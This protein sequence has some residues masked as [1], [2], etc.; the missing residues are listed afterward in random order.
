MQISSNIPPSSGPAAGLTLKHLVH[1]Q[2]GLKFAGTPVPSSMAPRETMESSDQAGQRVKD[3]N[4]FFK[5]LTT[6]NGV[7]ENHGHAE[8]SQYKYIDH[9]TKQGLEHENG[10]MQK[11][12][13]TPNPYEHVIGKT[14]ITAGSRNLAMASRVEYV[15]YDDGTVQKT[16]HDYKPGAF[17][18]DMPAQTGNE[19]VDNKA[20][21]NYYKAYK[22]GNVQL[23]ESVKTAA[24]GGYTVV[25]ANDHLSDD[26][27]GV[28]D[29]M[30][31]AH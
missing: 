4:D 6:R 21:S 28:L 15:E 1:E 26:A 11:G 19:E 14:E 31:I 29:E 25:R 13:D 8:I 16:V 24:G 5:G 12:S 2:Q 18:K 22:N 10:A 9:W 7:V 3:E 17:E 20:M 27:R 23:V 30:F